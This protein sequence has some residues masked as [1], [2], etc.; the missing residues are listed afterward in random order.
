MAVI[1][2]VF[3]QAC[4]HMLPSTVNGKLC[5]INRF[6]ICE[7]IHYD[8]VSRCTNPFFFNWNINRVSIC[9]FDHITVRHVS[10][11]SYRISV[12]RCF[13]YSIL[14]FLPVSIIFVYSTKRVLPVVPFIQHGS[15]DSI[16]SCFQVNCNAFCRRAD[17]FLL[18]RYLCLCLCVPCCY[19]VS[20]D[21]IFHLTGRS[22]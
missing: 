6:F 2:I 13:L 14:N 11:Y 8:P 4:E 22:F 16:V 15:F 19:A 12:K 10:C 18:N 7:K 21:I 5:L 17:P 9:V 1:S 3:G 20:S